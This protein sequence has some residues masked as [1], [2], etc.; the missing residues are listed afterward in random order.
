MRLGGPVFVKDLTPDSWIAALRREKYSAAY[1]P[2]GP[3]HPGAEDTAL[4]A[5]YRR[6]AEKAHILIPEVGAWS[7]PLSPVAA[8][9]KKALAKCRCALWIADE[10]G[11][12][13]A[14]NITGSR[15]RDWA[16]PDNK[17]LTAD[18]FDRIVAATRSII[19]AVKPKRACYTLEA[20]SYMFPDS[21]DSYLR[22][23]KAIDRKACAVH[24]DPVNLVTSPQVYYNTGALIRD[25]VQRLGPKIKSCHAKDILIQNRLTVHLEE[26]RP[27]LGNLDYPTLV[28][29]IHRLNPDLPLMLE[30]LPT[31][32]EY[33]A[34]AQHI[35]RVAKRIRV[36]I[37]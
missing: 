21:V 7:N 28:R 4:I 5:A 24:F 27:G 6:A 14:V 26:A 29:E 34:A 31:P 19:D 35:R 2:I 17:N 15:G 8:E 1:S 33:K 25:F 37:H 12:S 30:H 20:M 36:P 10:I 18:T 22:L 32:Q 3:D 16:G 23:I 13:S 9:R 11:A